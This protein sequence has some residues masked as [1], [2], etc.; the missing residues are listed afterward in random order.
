MTNEQL[1]A[2]F[3]CSHQW[4]RELKEKHSEI[5]YKTQLGLCMKELLKQRKNK[6]HNLF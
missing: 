4:C 1:K 3:L 5:N 6:E 2:W